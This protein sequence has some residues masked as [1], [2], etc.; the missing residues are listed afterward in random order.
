MYANGDGVT[1]DNVEAVK[2]YRKASDQGDAEAQSL[3][4]LMYANG[5]GV[6]KDSVEAV[7]WYRKASG[8]G[9]A[10][11]QNNLG[12]MYESGE[13]VPKDETEALAWYKV[14]AASG[15]KI[16]VKNQ[17]ALELRLGRETTLAAQQRSNALLKEIEAARAHQAGSAAADSSP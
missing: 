5:D 2:W 4:G 11:A 7:K 3:L 12:L 1:K 15:N 8:Q 17:N 14:A 9:N 10:M 13:G 6:T 16:A